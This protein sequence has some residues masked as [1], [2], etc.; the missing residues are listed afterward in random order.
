MSPDVIIT[1]SI[2]SS[3]VT[4]GV[5]SADGSGASSE[6]DIAPPPGV[7]EQAEVVP[8]PPQVDTAPQEAAAADEIPPPEVEPDEDRTFAVPETPPA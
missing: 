1:I 6:V 5:T 3:A 2:T 4:T 7:D 8:A